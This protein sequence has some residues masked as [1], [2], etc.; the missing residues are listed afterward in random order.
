MTAIRVKMGNNL[1]DIYFL[2]V[3]NGNSRKKC[4][5]CLTL[6]IK[7]PEQPH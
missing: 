6:T 5:I 4:E 3:N 2:K 7:I 1:T